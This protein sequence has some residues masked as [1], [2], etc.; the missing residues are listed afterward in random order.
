MFTVSPVDNFIQDDILLLIYALIF[1]YKTRQC[2]K[3]YKELSKWTTNSVL[4]GDM[5]IDAVLLLGVLLT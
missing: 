2:W 5:P 1:V 3:I 4:Y